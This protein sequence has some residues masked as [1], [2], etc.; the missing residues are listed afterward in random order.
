MKKYDTSVVK[1]PKVI[2]NDVINLLIFF[3][4]FYEQSERKWP[5]FWFLGLLIN[6]II[7]CIII[8]SCDNKK[9]E[10]ISLE[11]I[12]IRQFFPCQLQFPGEIAPFFL[13]YYVNIKYQGSY[14]MTSFKTLKQT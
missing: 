1:L 9:N 6:G 12:V 14:F 10:T 8:L 2:I 5:L 4:A 11:K 7:D 13:F 3:L